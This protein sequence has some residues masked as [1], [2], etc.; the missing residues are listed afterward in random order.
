MNDPFV[1][2]YTPPPPAPSK[3]LWMISLADLL[4]LLCSFFVMLYSLSVLETAKWSK[5]LSSMQ[6]Q[7]YEYK[8]KPD[9]SLSQEPLPNAAPGEIQEL[10]YLVTLLRDKFA[11]SPALKDTVVKRIDDRVVLTLP[12]TMQ[13]SPMQTQLTDAA[14]QGLLD[15]CAILGTINNRVEVVGHDAVPAPE[16]TA[17]TA[18]ENGLIRAQH[19]AQL[20]KELGYPHP[21]G[22]ISAGSDANATDNPYRADIVIRDEKAF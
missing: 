7:M 20:M 11:T 2:F 16:L 15:L 5:M 22:I 12:N 13:F 9:F 21:V 14:Q 19:V 6:P 3:V 17:S 10:P 8:E 4:S 1:D 18:L